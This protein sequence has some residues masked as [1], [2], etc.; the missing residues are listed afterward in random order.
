MTAPAFIL[1]RPQLGMNIGMAARAMGNF[2]LDQLRLV[3]PRD[4]WPNPEAGPPAAG[5]DHVLEA[6]TVHDSVAAA[7]ADCH[8]TFATTVRPRDMP[9]PVVTPREAAAMMREAAGKGLKSGILF[10]PERSGLTADDLA[11]VATIVTCPVNPGHG[12]LNLAQAVLLLGYEWFQAAAPAP[13]PAP[14][15]APAPHGEVAG[16]IAH[17]DQALD[18]AGY[19][20]VPDRTPA[21][22]RTLA[23]LL[24]RPNFTQEEVRTLRG[25]IRALG[26]ARKRRA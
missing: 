4:G 20:H 7:L 2:A 21:T 10:G 15:F 5:A 26:E 22:R 1:V 23:Q 13:A 12:S 9:K 17:L 3:E 16:L 25:I 8:L 11:P 18:A 24:T 19:Y 14:E 6:V